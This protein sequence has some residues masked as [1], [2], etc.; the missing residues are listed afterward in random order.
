MC[1]S[2]TSQGRRKGQPMCTTSWCSPTTRRMTLRWTRLYSPCQRRLVRTPFRS[3]SPWRSAR[4]R[5]DARRLG[6]Y[7]TCSPTISKASVPLT[8]RPRCSNRS[9]MGQLILRYQARRPIC[10]GRWRGVT[11]LVWQMDW[12]RSESFSQ[13]QMQTVCF[14][15]TIFDSLELSLTICR[16]GLGTSSSRAC[17]R[18]RSFPTGTTTPHPF[19]HVCGVTLPLCTR[20]A[21]WRV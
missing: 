18:R 13:L 10:G 11:R 5:W 6:A 15:R 14:I 9:W 3:C 1:G 7:R 17:G 2:L 8:I 21:E 20:L 4:M 16:R 19:R 12:I